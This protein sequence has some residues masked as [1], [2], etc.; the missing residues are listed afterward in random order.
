MRWQFIL[1]LAIKGITTNKVRS[2]LTVLGIVIG[3]SAVIALLA[4][5]EGAQAQVTSSVS[6]LGSNLITIFPGSNFSGPP[7]TNTDVELTKRDY[8]Y[9]NNETRFPGLAEV[10]PY[11]QKFANVTHGSDTVFASVK[12]VSSNFPGIV[13]SLQV[14]SGS[15]FGEGA[16]EGERNV[17]VIGQSIIDELFSGLDDSQI[18]GQTI[19][20][21]NLS[22]AVVGI[23]TERD[24][25]GFTDPNQDIFIPYTT[26]SSR[27]F[28][29]ANFGA[30]Y[31]TVEDIQ[32]IDATVVQIEEKLTEFRGLSEE[33]KDF[34]V[35][36]S[37]DLLT[38]ASQIT[39]IF[40]TLLSSIA[41]ISL[42]VGGIGIS[43]I[44]LVSV[45]ERT[46]E[47]G[48]RKAV[49]A[50]QGDILGQFLLE[51]VTLTLL[52]GLIGI[53][54]GVSLAVLIG[55]VA[56]LQANIS[57]NIVILATSVSAMVGIVF[58]FYP[59]YKAAKLDPI[60]AL[61]YE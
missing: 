47:I 31:S 52:G 9:L 37:E 10:S 21:K 15:F 54:L 59:A 38:T 4:L 55:N 44:M 34:T 46:R 30:I 22:F 19:S 29:T 6:S 12:A 39:A 57:L 24:S 16:V 25:T 53:V 61:R 27:V 11:T 18:V 13:D 60:E 36:T 26:A 51:A 17:A 32:L 58:G 43:N 8:N 48:L 50:R 35:F 3:I 49:G 20:I 2:L 45:T 1:K 42:I 41:A 40:T 33:D 28:G 56:N 5:G 23:Y 14:R 7:G